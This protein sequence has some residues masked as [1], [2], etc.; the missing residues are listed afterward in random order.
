M[1]KRGEVTSLSVAPG[2]HK[3]GGYVRTLF[4]MGRVTIPALDITTP[5]WAATKISNA[6][7]K[8]K[9]GFTLTKK[10]NS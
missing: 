7:T 10:G 5:S 6:V 8:D 4:G 1:L 2:K 9:P 3:L